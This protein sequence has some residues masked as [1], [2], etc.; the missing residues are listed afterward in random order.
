MA[1]THIHFRLADSSG[2]VLKSVLP[3]LEHLYAVAKFEYWVDESVFSGQYW[4]KPQVTKFEERKNVL[5]HAS[6]GVAA[7][8]ELGMELELENF[9][10][11]PYKDRV[12]DHRR[13]KI[14]YC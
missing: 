14:R 2:V 13:T 8:R 12:Y 11:V 6:P 1:V 10:C 7:T 9:S 3:A 5:E 4:D